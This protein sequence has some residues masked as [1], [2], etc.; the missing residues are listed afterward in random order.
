MEFKNNE[1]GFCPVCGSGDLEYGDME[2]DENGFFY[3]WNCE[4][5]EAIGKEFYN[6]EFC[7][8]GNV[9]TKDGDEVLNDDGY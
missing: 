2:P 9:V 6:A 5:C 3:E 8:H 1:E 4:N 7:S